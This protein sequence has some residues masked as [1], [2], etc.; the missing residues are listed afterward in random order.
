MALEEIDRRLEDRFALLRGGDRSAPGRH[1]TL[2]AVI[3]WSWN[4]LD[5]AER[6]ALGRLALF[7]DGFTL[8]AAE[9]VLGDDA[10]D[11]VEAVQG[12]VDQSMLSVREAPAGGRYRMLEMVREFGL[13]RLADA[14][15]EAA[16]RAAQRRW[17]AAYARHHGA[18][19]ASR[20][21]FAAIDAIG[22]EEVNLADELRGAIADGDRCSLVQLLSALGLFWTVRGEHVR[23]IVL[24]AATADALRDWQ[25]PPDL[26]NEAHAAVMITLSNTLMTGGASSG[27]LH[28]ILQRLG[29][30]ADDSPYLSGLLRVML[31]YDPADAEADA[32]SGRLRAAG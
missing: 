4:L 8:E 9:T 30:D 20:D 31:A 11:A 14:G 29:R 13:M 7:H 26:V 18:R 17:A 19:I 1:R 5:A 23:I 12:L 15:E 27:Q 25:P 21:Q 22:A 3:D 6:R 32:F 16:A 24:A 2:L 10:V 28:A